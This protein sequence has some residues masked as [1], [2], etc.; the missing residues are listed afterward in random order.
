[1]RIPRSSRRP[2]ALAITLGTLFGGPLA[3]TSLLASTAP[4]YQYDLPSGPLD[5]S[6]TRIARQAGQVIIVEPGLVDGLRAPRVSGELTLEQ[7]FAQ[8]LSGSGLVLARS[9]SGTL[10]V[11]PASHDD[12]LALSP[13]TVN[14]LG[15]NTTT[16]GSGSYTSAAVNIG[17]G[18]QAVRDIPQAV[19]VITR[20]KMDDQGI[21][22]IRQALLSA[23]GVT[24]V[25]NEPGGH[26]YSR[27]FFIQSYQFD[28]VPLERQLYAR[29]SA[30]NS[31]M[32]L[33]DR[34][35]IM[36]GPQGLFE[37]EGDPSGSVN[38][39]RKRPTRDN[40]VILTGKAGS[41]DR[42]GLQADVAGPLDSNG[43]IR[44]RLV[45]NQETADSFRDHMDSKT[46]TLYAALDFDLGSATTLGV[47]FS[48]EKPE[49]AL[50]W[51]GLPSYANGSMPDYQRSTNL[52]T[53]WSYAEK[54]QDT[55][56]LDLTH[57]FNEDWKLKA[58][59]VDTREANEIKYLLRSGRL[60]P[61]ST[62]RGDVYYFDMF[63]KNRGADVHLT[64]NTELFGRKLALTAGGNYSHQRSSDLWGWI[65]SIDT[66]Y[67]S[68]SQPSS[69]P[70]P[71]AAQILATNRM[72]DGYRSD[73]K[74]LY[75]MGR[76][77]LYGPLSL[78]LGARLSSYEQTYVSDGIWGYSESTAKESRKVTPFAA[79][80][81]RLGEQWSIHGSY[82][83]IFKPQTQR[84]VD[85][86]FLSP[87]TGSNYELGLKGELLGGRV[88]TS[89]ALFR[90]EQEG[91]AF[92]DGS[93]DQTIADIRCGGTC[94]RDTAQVLS[95]GFEAEVTGEVLRD[96]QLSASYTY[97][98]TR[99]R[100]QDTPSVGYDISANTGLPRHVL[101]IW[102]DYRLPADWQRWSVGTGLSSQSGSSS[103]GYYDRY[104]GG[105]TLLDARV[106][107]RFSDNL[108]A[109]LNVDNL[110]D[111]KYFSSISYDHNFYGA[112]RSFLLTLQYRL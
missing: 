20:Q 14:A 86:N 58:S 106:A 93:V 92:E 110:T 44:G 47:G 17:K 65:R 52:S 40:Q 11:Q 97:T 83:E 105:Y 77:E 62:L 94:Y 99:Y 42:Y 64:G 108:S 112:P 107:Y 3:A 21:T 59:L 7:A 111:K 34:V 55:W 50:D 78:T 61:P 22:D 76:Y 46:R 87:V 79:L 24:M 8:A 32:A 57:A 13:L 71:S 90:T 85:G 100:G 54:T 31:D 37:G 103:F 88:N 69:A 28:G 72:D 41:W 67:S 82:A 101:R 63:S 39:V 16:E 43:A 104:Q 35:E 23:P 38:L 18:E 70:E 98:G 36:R 29:G 66:A 19:S 6:L 60:G 102:G 68:P 30:F 45:A 10:G 26:F 53:P 9:A 12:A 91:V 75:A 48:R 89:F 95:Q 2:L 51:T 80:T 33:Y 4:T 15:V 27:G 25:S 1:M 84:N 56:Y 81:Y 109:A 73:K 74:G 49:S 5:A 96:L